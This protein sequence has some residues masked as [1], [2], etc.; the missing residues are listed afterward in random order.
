MSVTGGDMGRRRKP[1][2]WSGGDAS[3][4]KKREREKAKRDLLKVAAQHSLAVHRGGAGPQARIEIPFKASERAPTHSAMASAPRIEAPLDAGPAQ[5][6]QPRAMAPPESTEL[7]STVV[8][9]AAPGRA[10]APNVSSVWRSSP[11][12]AC[13]CVCVRACSR[14]PGT[15]PPR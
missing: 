10:D 8:D 13:A 3:A 7:A 1:T 5:Q 2:G 14:G 15:L 6:A 9:G 11:A 12:I 4:R